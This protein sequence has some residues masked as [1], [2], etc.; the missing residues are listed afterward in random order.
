[1]PD[2]L[3]EEEVIPFP[4]FVERT[5]ASALFGVPVLFKFDHNF[6][7]RSKPGTLVAG[8][9]IEVSL[10]RVF[11]VSDRAST[12][13]ARS[14]VGCL[15]LSL[16]WRYATISPCNGRSG[17]FLFILSTVRSA[18]IDLRK[19]GGA[20]FAST[21][22]H[23]T[24]VVFSPCRLYSAWSGQVPCALSQ[25]CVLLSQ[26]GVHCNCC[27]AFASFATI[28]FLVFV[29]FFTPSKCFLNVKALSVFTP[30]RLGYSLFGMTVS[31]IF[32]SNFLLAFLL[33]K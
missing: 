17:G 32:T 19:S 31:L 26:T 16:F 1:M 24:R 33:F 23:C 25:E 21:G 28:L 18:C 27:V 11:H 30:R 29:L 3:S 20:M 5:L 14:H 6:R 15:G 4:P 12:G 8:F 2:R 10:Q 9:S 13:N 7:R 22:S